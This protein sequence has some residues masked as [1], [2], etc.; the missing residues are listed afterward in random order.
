[1]V[2]GTKISK[3]VEG[4]GDYRIVNKVNSSR[5]RGFSFTGEG[6]KIIWI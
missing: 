2:N 5:V 6:Y 3:H 4:K 1:M